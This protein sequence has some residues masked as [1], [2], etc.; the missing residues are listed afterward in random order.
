MRTG[1][2]VRDVMH[3]EFLGVSESDSLA[4]AARLMLSEGADCLVVLR[5]GEP[6]G[7][8]GP[9]DALAAALK[10]DPDDL[11]V[12]SVMGPPGPTVEADTRLETVEER[13]VSEGASRLI[14]TVEDEAV[15]VITDRDALAAGAARENSAREPSLAVTGGGSGSEREL[16]ADSTDASGSA[17]QSICEVCGSL[18][19]DLTATNGRVICTD[20][21]EV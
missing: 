15:G 5:G 21:R 18:V 9:R 13:L 3:R 4:D 16:E 8:L 14:V 12:G 2:T 11:T 17:T 7:C 10:A 6:V 1:T 19:P 20:C